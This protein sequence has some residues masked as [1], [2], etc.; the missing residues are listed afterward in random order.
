[1]HRVCAYLRRD[2]FALEA[3]PTY[4]SRQEGTLSRQR[5]KGSVG[6]SFLAPLWDVRVLDCMQSK[7][8]VRPSQSYLTIQQEGGWDMNFE[9]L[10]VEVLRLN[11]YS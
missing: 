6:E 3:A 1:M 4:W 9:E 5:F 10:E 2:P 8:T 7:K 11:N